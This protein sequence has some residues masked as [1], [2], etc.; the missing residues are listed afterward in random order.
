MQVPVGPVADGG[1]DTSL[2]PTHYTAWPLEFMDT[3]RDVGCYAREREWE[4]GLPGV[5]LDKCNAALLSRA[6]MQWDIKE[7]DEGYF[8]DDDV[9]RVKAI[10]KEAFGVPSSLGVSGFTLV[11]ALVL[12]SHDSQHKFV[13]HVKDGQVRTLFG[14]HG[15]MRFEMFGS[16]TF[17][18]FRRLMTASFLQ[19]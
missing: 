13:V 4:E 6:V 17:D 8:P 16:E 9:R 14:I 2:P 19:F 11:D 12:S 15:Q 18:T 1:D 5:V 10:V 3:V 7:G